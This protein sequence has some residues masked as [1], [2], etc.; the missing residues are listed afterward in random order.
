M[1]SII[2]S[3][4]RNLEIG[5]GGNLAFSGRGE[6]G[7]FKAT[8]MDRKILMGRNTFNSLPRRLEGRKYYVAS[9]EKSGF[10]EWVTVVDDLDTFLK[11]WQNKPEEIFVIGGGAI[12]KATLPYAKKLY[13]T[14]IAAERPDADVFF[15]TF[16]KSKYTKTEVGRGEFDDGL[17]FIRFI[18]EQK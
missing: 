5:Q 4:G 6:L 16:D 15:P 14:E 8:T 18:Y 12:Y 1:I 3:I 7:Y 2:A 10:P 11:E 17:K 9:Y 13:L